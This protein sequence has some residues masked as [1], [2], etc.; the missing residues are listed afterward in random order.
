MDNNIKYFT[1]YGERCSGTNFLESAIKE[2]FQLEITWK[3][4]WKHFFGH[5][6]FQKAPS[7]IDKTLF[8]GII[9][10]PIE[11]LDSFY[12]E[13]HHI[14]SQNR[15]SPEVFL[16]NEHYSTI[17]NYSTIEKMND[18]NIITK[19]R[20]KNIFELRKVKNDYLIYDLQKYIKKYILIKYEDLK[21]NYNEILSYIENTFNLTR[22]NKN[23][24][25]TKII[26]YKGDKNKKIYHEKKV[27]F[28]E[29]IINIIKNN[30]D[31]KQESLLGYEL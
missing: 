25:F 27:N 31:E 28:S 30:L 8:I 21:N 15:I 16:L 17:D 11:W 14:P 7:D 9:R 2:N 12:K 26:N 29:E 20:Y 19:E 6:N 5:Y 23:L 22:I 1:I 24:P 13:L 10:N 4:G 18:R 3:Y